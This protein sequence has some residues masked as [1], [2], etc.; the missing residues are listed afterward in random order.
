MPCLSL[1]SAPRLLAG[2]L[3][4]A[5]GAAQADSLGCLIGP[6]RTADVGS[7]VIGVLDEVLVERGDLVRRGQV[8]AT[9]RNHVE[10]AQLQVAQSR[11]AA[12]A[13]LRSARMSHE[14]AQRK[15]ERAED[16]FRQEFVS[17][18][19]LDQSI[20]EAQVAEA[21]WRQSQ[22]QARHA[23]RERQLAAAQLEQRSIRSPIDGV[24]VERH[25]DAGERVDERPIL[26]IATV[27]PL[28]VEVVLPAALFGRVQAGDALSVKPDLAALATV[29]ALAR[30]VDRVID[31]ASN[32]FRARLELANPDASIPAGVRC[33]A[34]LANGAAPA[35]PGPAAPGAS[36]AGVSPAP[37]AT[38]VATAPSLAR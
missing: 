36:R 29:Q 18:Q 22:E 19:A 1:P 32:T 5:A 15:R 34:M 25:L 28:R 12:E 10:R 17:R 8:I 13:E 24:V 6:S 38:A 11:A 30:Q 20:A 7:P 14:F 2:F 26:K 16:L 21:R 3:V 35:A 33:K 37:V 9:L 4:L 23:E 27:T 31:P